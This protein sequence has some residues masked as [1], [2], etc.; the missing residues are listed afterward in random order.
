MEYPPLSRLLLAAQNIKKE[1][2]YY[3]PAVNRVRF[4]PDNNINTMSINNSL[5]IFFNEAFVKQLTD[6]ELSNVFLHEIMHYLNDHHTRYMNNNLKDLL[7]FYI[8]NIAMDLEINEFIDDLPEGAYKAENFNL[9]ERRSYEEYLQLLK[10]PMNGPNIDDNDNENQTIPKMPMNDL[11][12]DDYDVTQIAANQD[13]LEKLKEE[14]EEL[15]NTG[16]SSES[17]DKNRKINKRKYHWKQVFQSVLSTKLT[18]IV[19]GFKYRTFEKANRRYVHTPDIILPVYIDRKIK[20]S[21]VIIMDVSGSMYEITEKMYGIMKG[22]INIQDMEID[23]TILETDAAVLNVIRGF[24]LNRESIDSKYGGGTDMGEG[25]RYIKEKKINPDLIV[26]MT[27]SF[28]PWPD[29]PILSD[30]TVVLTDN[31]EHY[32][33]PYPMYPVI[34][35]E[36]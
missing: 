10:M 21:L 7:P 12:I 27:D 3:S 23:I 31:P 5:E 11:N 17:G 13:M 36:P 1:Y 8:H 9:S 15:K 32:H 24:D 20:I 26:V 28:T 34:F 35:D 6:E 22:M 16:N 25:L 19:A 14:C 18:E 33:G 4:K 2:F 29:P 30:K